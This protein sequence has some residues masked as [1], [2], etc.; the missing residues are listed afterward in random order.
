[1]SKQP[2]SKTKKSSYSRSTIC[3]E[4]LKGV[5]WGGIGLANE[6]VGELTFELVVVALHA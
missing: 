5:A 6:G 4:E 2:V 3:K 1:M